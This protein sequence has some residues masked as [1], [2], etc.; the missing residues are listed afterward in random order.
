MSSS[1]GS[2]AVISLEPVDSV[3]IQVLMD[4][5][6]DP[7]LV[8]HGPARRATLLAAGAPSVPSSVLVEGCAPDM[9]VAEHGFSALVTA[10]K[11][12]VTHRILF[13]T[14]VTPTGAVE[15]MRRLGLSLGDVEA[16]VLSHGHWDHVTGMEGV[17]A[18]LGQPSLPVYIHPAFWRRRRII[19]PG[20]E[21]RELPSPSRAGLEDAGFAIVEEE[22]PSF[23]LDGSVLVTGEVDRT[24]EYE[25]GFR[26][27]DAYLD[28]GWQA[29]PLILDDQALVVSVRGKGLVVVSGCGHA[30]IVNT[31]RYA[32]KLT[33]E[34]RLF[35]L[36]GGFHLSGPAFEP[37]IES[38][39]DGL[40]A[41]APALLV[42]SHCTG[43]KAVHRLAETFPAA[44]IQ[45][46]VGTRI[47]L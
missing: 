11:G 34:D 1:S 2:G 44:F 33:G 5:V 8:D 4:N 36:I 19:F 10:R 25:V 18:E 43:W 6:T 16:I 13:D 37:I 47:E 32:L 17:V 28:G 14:G 42:P 41:L 30:G 45:G 15:N 35:G 22:Q 20:G 7:L 27:H 26:G 12:E 3:S 31:A 9:L 39:I 29:D 46:A 40:A 21:P 23:L 24:T 38:T